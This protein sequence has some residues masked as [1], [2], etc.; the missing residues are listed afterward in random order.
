[1]SNRWSIPLLVC[2]AVMGYLL[3]GRSL[4]A[5]HDLLPFRTGE[6]VTFVF[7]PDWSRECRV[8]EMRGAF[9]RCQNDPGV[10]DEYWINLDEVSGVRK[11]TPGT[12]V[13]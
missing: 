4:Q 3:G 7:A 9:V 6:V 8:E 13:R 11:R 10:R 5:Q 1:M 2:A 12:R